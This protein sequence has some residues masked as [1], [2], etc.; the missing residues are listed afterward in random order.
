MRGAETLYRWFDLL[1]E[2]AQLVKK[3]PDRAGQLQERVVFGCHAESFPAAAPT[4]NRHVYLTSSLPFLRLSQRLFEIRMP[5]FRQQFKR[6]QGLMGVFAGWLMAIKN[7]ERGQWVLALLAPRAGER[8]LEVGFGPGADARR[9]LEALGPRGKLD[10]V[11]ASAVMVKQAQSRNRRAVAAQRA[12]FVQGDLEAGLPYAN[13]VFDAAVSINCAQFWSDL[14]R[15]ISELARVVNGTG[16]VV[17]AVQPRN[18]SASAQDSEAWATKL[19]AAG[20]AA[21]LRVV[22]TQLSPARPPVAAVVLAHAPAGGD[23]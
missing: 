1:R 10:G 21:G 4:D 23:P 5:S 12:A 22:S 3:P 8:I 7:R 13:S 9:L 15:G 11:D 19:A 2:R 6:P 17:I 20:R 16:R 18:Q 14:E